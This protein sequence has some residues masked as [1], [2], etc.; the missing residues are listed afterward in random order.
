MMEV[1]SMQQD[2]GI[3]ISQGGPSLEAKV[4]RMVLALQGSKSELPSLEAVYKPGF[5]HLI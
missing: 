2:F 3:Q 4:Q 1:H 5:V